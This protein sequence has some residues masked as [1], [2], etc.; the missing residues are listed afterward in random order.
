MTTLDAR[1]I[2]LRPWEPTDVAP[3]AAIAND[4]RIW[5][6]LRDRF[7]H[8]YGEADAK[9]WI[10]LVSSQP[11]PTT[12]FAIT[13]DGEVIGGIGLERFDDVHRG[14]AEIGYWLGAAHWGRGHAPEAVV[15]LTTY[16]FETLGLQRIQ[17]G[18]YEWNPASGRVLVKAGYQL[19][20]RLRRHVCKDGRVGD[21]LLYAT[22]RE[23][24]EAR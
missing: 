4:R 7:P 15:A 12:S 23:G 9:A 10:E 13:L 1:S 22:I 5:Q 19:E 17:A 20:G 6:N 18:V 21:V 16:G 24:H 11:L 8:P 2:T 3:L 14:T